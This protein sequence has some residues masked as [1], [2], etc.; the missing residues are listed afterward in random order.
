[1]FNDNS[2]EYEV[3]FCNNQTVDSPC[4]YK[5]HEPRERYSR[6]FL[7]QLLWASHLS[8]RDYVCEKSRSFHNAVDA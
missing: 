4:P 8:P 6:R 1:M 5:N 7:F 2:V 3:T